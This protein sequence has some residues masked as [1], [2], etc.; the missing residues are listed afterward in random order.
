MDSRACGKKWIL[1][2]SILLAQNVWITKE[3]ALRLLCHATASAVSRN[4]GVAELAC[5]ATKA[6]FC[7]TRILMG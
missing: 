3:A 6:A 4:D 2:K 1:V 5:D 7:Q